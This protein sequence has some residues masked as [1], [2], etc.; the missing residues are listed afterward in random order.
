MPPTPVAFNFWDWGEE[1]HL[2]RCQRPHP[3]DG[4]NRHVVIR[5]PDSEIIRHLVSPTFPSVS[6]A[7][8]SPRDW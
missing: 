3:P 7:A 1:M 6:D 4:L 8:E 2:V 5:R